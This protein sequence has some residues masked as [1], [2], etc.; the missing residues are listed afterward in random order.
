MTS[1]GLIEAPPSADELRKH[2]GEACALLKALANEDRLVLLCQLTT[3]QQNVS[4]LEALTGIRQP[5]LSQQL[6]VLRAEGLVD[7]EKVGRFVYYRLAS[8]A[9]M[10]VMQTLWS[11]YCAPD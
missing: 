2:A 9:V 11:I 8:G 5:T 10:P 4:E 1:P 7:T 3:G 6:A